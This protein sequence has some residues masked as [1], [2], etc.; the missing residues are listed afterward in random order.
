[1]SRFAVISDIHGNLHA[2]QAVL[3]RIDRLSVDEILCLG[4][5]VGYGPHPGRCLDLVMRC[6]SSTVRGNHDE[7]IINPQR[8]AEFNGLAREAIVWTREAL[9]P[10]HKDALCRLREVDRPHALV[11]C[12][13]DCPVRGPSDYVHDSYM[14]AMAFG[15][16][17]TPI[18]LLGHTHVPLVF[19]APGA[20]P[21]E[22]SPADVIAHL[23]PDGQGIELAGDRRYICN[24][25]SVGQPRDADPRA[26]FAVLDLRA[27]TFTVHRTAYDLEAARL[28]TEEA[29]LPSVLGDRLAIGA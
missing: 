22:V 1:M 20:G 23:T 7:A 27:R 29:G 11:T 5:I 14:A 18:C 8:E 28:A 19:E 9:G 15:G 12:V 21:A 4:D 13:H 16:L 3:A 6:C 24:P 26:S 17:T 10:L 25:G 2:L